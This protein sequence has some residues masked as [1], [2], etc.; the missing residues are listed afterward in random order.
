MSAPL[1]SPKQ[2]TV[3][4]WWVPGNPFCGKEAIICDGAVRSG[5]TMAM[6]LGFFLWAMCSF[7]G[8]RFALCGKTR[9]HKR[10]AASEVGCLYGR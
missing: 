1:F 10:G 4:T 9:Y 2:K 5:K 8:K 3:L 6:G 7:D